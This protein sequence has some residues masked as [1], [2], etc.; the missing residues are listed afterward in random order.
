[1]F[2]YWYPLGWKLF[3]GPACDH[4]PR[5]T[6]ALRSK[7]L[8]PET[9]INGTSHSGQATADIGTAAF[10]SWHSPHWSSWRTW[11]HPTMAR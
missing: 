6:A 10:L 8:K 5:H 3:D 2:H 9:R 4:T 7:D 1:M 11:R